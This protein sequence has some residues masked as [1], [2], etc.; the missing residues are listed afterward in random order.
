M[1]TEHAAGDRGRSTWTEGG[2]RFETAPVFV[3]NRKPV[4][5][6]FDRVQAAGGQISGAPRAHALQ[7]SQGRGKGIGLV[8]HRCG[9]RERPDRLEIV[10]RTHAAR[11]TRRTALL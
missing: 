6:I 7:V 4:Q 3:P 8:R 10:L 1:R 11:A 2:D 5:E 9:R